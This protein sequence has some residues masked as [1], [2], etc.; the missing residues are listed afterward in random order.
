MAV[1]VSGR[2]K[3]LSLLRNLSIGCLV[4]SS[5]PLAQADDQAECKPVLEKA[6]KAMGGAD[7]LNK[8]MA[9]TWKA[10][11][12]ANDNGKELVLLTEGT[13]Q[14]RNQIKLDADIQ[15]G[16]GSQKATLVVNGE[17]SWLKHGDKTDDAPKEIAQFIK[18]F[19]YAMR[20]PQ[21]LTQLQDK[22]FAL[23]PLGELKIDTIEAAGIKITHKDYKE[24][25]VY[26]DKKEGT[27]IKAEITLTDPQSRELTIEFV[28]SD[29]KDFDG[30]KAPSKIV[31][32][33]IDGKDFV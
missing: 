13:W 1:V 19:S 16:G 23:S 11:T 20:M 30:I 3:M 25:R 4:L 29:Y 14:G 28:F 22:E 17:N 33:G 9:G 32:R 26:F 6:I 18:N 8:L 21:L 10:K 27:P 2:Y 15:V 7:K 31:I 5:F 12:T 24:V